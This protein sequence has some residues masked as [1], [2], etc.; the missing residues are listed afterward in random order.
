MDRDRPETIHEDEE[1]AQFNRENVN[2]LE[3]G[4]SSTNTTTKD[5]TPNR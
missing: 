4:N 5:A 1:S 3:P 2:P